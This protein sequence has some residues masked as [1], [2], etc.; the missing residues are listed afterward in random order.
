MVTGK[1]IYYS[2]NSVTCNYEIGC[3]NTLEINAMDV[4]INLTDYKV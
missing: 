2:I 4:N 3:V 1:G